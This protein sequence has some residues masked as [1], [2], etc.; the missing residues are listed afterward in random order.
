MKNDYS[1]GYNM[2][3]TTFNKWKRRIAAY[4]ASGKSMREFAK[5]KDFAAGSLRWYKFAI[6]RLNQSSVVPTTVEIS[7]PVIENMS[8]LPVIA[9]PKRFVFVVNGVS[10]ETDDEASIPTLIRAARFAS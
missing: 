1:A 9:K 10:L 5:G 6:A 8:P 7:E 2:R 4:E 3:P